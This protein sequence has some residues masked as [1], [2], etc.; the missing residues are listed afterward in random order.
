MAYNLNCKTV[1]YNVQEKALILN[2]NVKIDFAQAE[3]QNIKTTYNE[4]DQKLEFTPLKDK[5]GKDLPS[6]ISK[7]DPLIQIYNYSSQ[8]QAVTMFAKSMT[9]CNSTSFP[10][11]TGGIPSTCGALGNIDTDNNNL[12]ISDDVRTSTIGTTG[13]YSA[14]VY[15]ANLSSLVSNKSDVTLINW[16]WEGQAGSTTGNISFFFWNATSSAWNFLTN[17]SGTTDVTKYLSSTSSDYVNSSFYTHFLAERSATASAI[18][19]DYVSLTV[20]YDGGIVT[21]PVANQEI[22]NSLSFILN[23]SQSKYT[24]VNYS[25]SGGLHNYSLCTGSTECQGT[26]TASRQ[27]YYNLSVYFI[28]PDG[29]QVSKTVS[30]LFVGNKTQFIWNSN[31]FSDTFIREN[32]PTTNNNDNPE[33]WIGNS[34]GAESRELLTLGIS[35]L[36]NTNIIINNTIFSYFVGG[37]GYTFDFT[38]YRINGTYDTTTTTWNKRNSSTNWNTGGLGNL[39]YFQNDNVTFSLLDTSNSEFSI[40]NTWIKNWADGT[41]TNNGFIMISPDYGCSTFRRHSN[42]TATTT[43]RPYLN[44]TYY[45]QNTAPSIN[46]VT[47]NYK[48]T[49][50]NVFNITYNYTDDNDYVKDITLFLND[51]INKTRGIS[52]DLNTNINFTIIGLADATYN[53][54]IQV[55][56]SDDLCNS[57]SLYY[58]TISTDAPA[59][60][61]DYPLTNSYFNNG[62]NLYFNFTATDSNGLSTCELWGNWTGTWAKNYTWL[63]T[64]AVQNFTTVNV[65]QGDAIYKWNIWC[66]DTTNTATFSPFNRTFTIDTT[67]PEVNLTSITPTAGSQTISFDVQATD[68]NLNTCKYSIFNSS[69][70]I[71][72]LNNNVSVS[73][74]ST[75][76]SATVSKY[77]TYNLT[78]YGIDKAGNE[79]SSIK[80]FTTTAL[81]PLT[82]SSGGGGGGESRIGVIG[83]A[84]GNFSKSYSNLEREAIY[85]TINNFCSIKLRQGTFAVSDYSKSCSL[86]LNDFPTIKK[87][88]ANL[89]IDAVLT[90]FPTFYEMYKTSQLFQGYE[91]QKNIDFYQLYVSQLGLV[92]LL[93]LSPSQIDTPKIIFV[94]GGES[95][96]I[97]TTINS[98]K[99]L[100]SCEVIS[101]E[102]PEAYWS[103]SLIGTSTIKVTLFMNNTKFFS[104]IFSTVISIQTDTDDPT[105][106]EIK[107]PQIIFRIYDLA[108]IPPLYLIAIPVLVVGGIFVYKKY[109]KKKNSK[110]NLGT[111]L[112]LQ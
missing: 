31:G 1:S 13:N 45:S 74:V 49:N 24:N 35:S 23:T 71:D 93:Q 101:N 66:N 2:D 12:D 86:S 6:D 99:P 34:C 76:N 36:N 81:A 16:T 29:S 61:L 108:N 103:C 105:K 67:F 8:F 63:P 83:I 109:R 107:K 90:D 47:Q 92:T 17:M 46:I 89:G 85:S 32:N 79:N 40:N 87:N 51:K 27:G 84:E 39:D 77:A 65:T 91:S 3:T 20:N 57:S 78:F 7:I 18:K 9:S 62:T 19:T 15:Y 68:I 33:W 112:K 38:L 37:F 55:C 75:G 104:K 54:S 11:T 25:F 96:Q 59:I 10:P 70:G 52:T 30:N 53:Y 64:S 14:E 102:I 110:L 44:V 42:E 26:I 97:S 41:Y 58:F 94:T 4:K 95:Y 43:S 73:C 5:D 72:G 82:I 60:N 48:T 80:S 22:L 21:T 56:D 88:L 28:A 106:V 98:N 69:G 50:S 111:Y 100:K